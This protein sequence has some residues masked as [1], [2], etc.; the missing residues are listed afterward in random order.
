MYAHV[1]V[2]TIELNMTRGHNNPWGFYT[3]DFSSMM[4]RRS[5]TAVTNVPLVK[6]IHDVSFSSKTKCH[7]TRDNFSRILIPFGILHSL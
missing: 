7:D 6:N 4:S 1:H 3:G 2:F 5:G